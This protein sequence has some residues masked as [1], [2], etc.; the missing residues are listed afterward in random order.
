MFAMRI[1]LSLIL[2]LALAAGV[3]YMAAGRAAAPAIQITQPAKLVGMDSTLE[4]TVEAPQGTLTRLEAVLEQGGKATPLFSLDSPGDAVVRQETPERMRV[5]R[6]LGKR[7]VP[8]LQAGDATVKVNATRTALFGVRTRDASVSR[9]FQARFTPPR[10]GVVSS[11]HFVNF[12]SSEMVVYRVTPPDAH[13]GVQVGD[14]FYPGYPA[15]NAGVAGADPSLKVAFFALLH[16]QDL[17]TPIYLAA[18]DEAGNQSRSSFEYRVFPKA[19]RKSRIELSDAF[20]QRVVPE[21]AEHAPELNLTLDGGESYLPAFLKVNND[22]RRSN[23]DFIAALAA[24]SAPEILWHGPFRPLGNASIESSFADH[25][26][27]FH[28]GREVDQQ[29]HLGFD[30]AVTVNI[31]VLAAND[32]KVVHAD[33]LGIYGNTVV[34][35]HGMGLGS[36]YAHLSSIDVKAGDEVKKEQQLGRSGMTGLAGGDH[37]HFSMLLQGRPVNAVEWWDPHWIEDR[38]IRKLREAK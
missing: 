27:Y 37:L 30:L 26:T 25:R 22:L 1:L 29:V 32:G 35:D 6:P 36:L 20:L 7:S 28:N 17:K 11:H 14:V 21:I 23:A 15:A 18:R 16:D 4:F 34:L 10:A 38:I 5:S 19:F 2:A 33:Y 31:P 12:G 9:P 8:A 3:V 13:S 24:K